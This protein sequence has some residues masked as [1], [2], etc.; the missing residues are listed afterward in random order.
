[1]HKYKLPLLV[2]TDEGL[3]RYLAQVLQQ[4][5]GTLWLVLQLEN[6]VYM[7]IKLAEWLTE[8]RIQKLIIVITGAESNQ[9]L[10]RW[11]FNLEADKAVT[12]DG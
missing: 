11:V 6:K 1:M 10:E 12:I 7:I 8:S 9:T 4:V 3:K 5:S 2:T